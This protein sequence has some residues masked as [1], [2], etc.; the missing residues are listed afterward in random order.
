MLPK[1]IEKRFSKV[2][3]EI[4]LPEENKK[5]KRAVSHIIGART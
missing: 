2:K 4:K 1:D 3:K 5:D